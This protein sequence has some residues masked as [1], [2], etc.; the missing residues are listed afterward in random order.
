MRPSSYGCY[1]NECVI[2]KCF[3]GKRHVIGG[4]K[5][6]IYVEHSVYSS[7]KQIGHFTMS[8]SCFLSLKIFHCLLCCIVAQDDSN[9]LIEDTFTKLTSIH[10]L[11]VLELTSSPFNW[12]SPLCN[13]CT[14]LNVHN[15]AVLDDIRTEW[16]T[17]VQ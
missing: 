1:P 6:D 12:I 4:W 5:I 9:S 14:T 17:Y 10:L 8:G 15:F 13:H 3:L 16:V 2:C 11:I 7:S